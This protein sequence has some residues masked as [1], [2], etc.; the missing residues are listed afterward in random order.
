MRTKTCLITVL[1]ITPLVRS[2]AQGVWTQLTDFGGTARDSAIA[3]SIDGKGYIGTGSDAGVRTSDFWEYDPSTN[4]WTRKADFPGAPIWLATGFSIGS[5]GYIGTGTVN[6]APG[7]KR[8]F[9][10]YD[11]ATDTW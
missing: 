2:H 5:K 6:N 8:W 10:E 1:L 9:A 11:P 3:F 7:S 4:T